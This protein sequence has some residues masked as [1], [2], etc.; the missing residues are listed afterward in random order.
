VIAGAAEGA[1]FQ[2]AIMQ[3]IVEMLAGSG[4][5]EEALALAERAVRAGL[6][7]LVWL[8]R[9]PLLA[10]LASKPRYQQL[11]AQLHARVDATLRASG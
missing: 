2:H 7:D 4:Q 5:D 6:L 3:F 8:E 11:H 10:A 1:R 9:C